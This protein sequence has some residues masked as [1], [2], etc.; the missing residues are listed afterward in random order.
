MRGRDCN[1][2]E[3]SKDTEKKEH[4]Y[5]YCKFQTMFVKIKDNISHIMFMIRVKIE[6]N[7]NY[8]CLHQSRQIEKCFQE[9]KMFFCDDMKS[10]S[11]LTV[12]VIL[13]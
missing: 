8:T 3:R 9:K 13:R 12:Q 10:Y 1:S 4:Y 11:F 6:L 2:E 7:E 5:Y